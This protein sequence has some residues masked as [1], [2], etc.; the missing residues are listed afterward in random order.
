MF[1][2]P[3]RSGP[4]PNV[5]QTTPHQ[6][7]DQLAPVH[8]QQALAARVFALPDVVEHESL[9]SVPG[10]RALCLR[11]EVPAGAPEAFIAAREFAHLHPHYDGSLHIRLPPAL[12]QEALDK[13]WAEPHF[14]VHSGHLPG[15]Y[16]MLYGPRD[17]AELDIIYGMIEASY[18][19]AGGRS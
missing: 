9:V 12:A 5:R 3:A 18:H 8:L 4:R 15:H 13:G 10:A 7:L 14:L 17:E 19:W 6:Q 1:T 11:Q 2:L 16:V